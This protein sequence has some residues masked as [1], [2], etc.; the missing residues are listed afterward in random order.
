MYP[1][2]EISPLAASELHCRIVM[3]LIYRPL[4]TELLKIAA[5]KRIATVSGLEMFLAQGFAQFELWSGKRS[6]EAPM[7][8]ALVAALRLGEKGTRPRRGTR[9]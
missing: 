9:A 5:R 7:R 8:R 2:T 4:Q 6:P 3:D 1:H